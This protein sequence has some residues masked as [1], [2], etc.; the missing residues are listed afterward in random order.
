MDRRSTII[1]VTG[2]PRSGTSL[3]MQTLKLLG[4]DVAGG[5]NTGNNQ[6]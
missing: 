6:R 2:E 1:A 4:V 3:M 5:L